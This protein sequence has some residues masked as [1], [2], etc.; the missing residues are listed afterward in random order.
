MVRVSSSYFRFAPLC[1]YVIFGV[2]IRGVSCY[3]KPQAQTYKT[4]MECVNMGKILT[5]ESY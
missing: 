5:I 2:N 3:V 4:T 1:V